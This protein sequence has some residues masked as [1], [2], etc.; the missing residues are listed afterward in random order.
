MLRTN[1]ARRVPA[2]A[3]FVLVLTACGGS[4][5]A[6]TALT[7]VASGVT[8]PTTTSAVDTAVSVDTTTSIALAAIP[9]STTAMANPNIA[10]GAATTSVA[11]TQKPFVT[12][13]LRSAPAVATAATIDDSLKQIDSALADT[14]TS[15]ASAG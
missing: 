12:T 14:D 1:Y 13:P 2:A 11:K 8:S 4:N 7:A 10:D 5:P 9:T 15:M 6:H 3:L